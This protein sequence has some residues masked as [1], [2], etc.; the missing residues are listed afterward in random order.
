[1][2]HI[3]IVPSL[4]HIR[5]IG[6]ARLLPLGQLRREPPVGSNDWPSS[7]HVS[8]RGQQSHPL[9]SDEEGEDDG[10]RAGD[11]GDAVDE[12]AAGAVGADQLA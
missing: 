6:P 3:L 10:G 1:M 7:A 8:Q 2:N 11:A 5:L 9:K 4:K 12:G